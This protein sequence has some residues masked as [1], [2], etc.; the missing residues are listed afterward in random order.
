MTWDVI[1]IGLGAMGSATAADLAGRG[2]RV[3]GLD[4]YPPAHDRG[5]SHGRSR[6]I[7][8]AYF[9]D[10]SY[11]PMVWRSYELWADLERTS[12]RHLFR[13]TGGI[14][15]GRPDT[16]LVRGS[17]ESARIHRLA[18]EV[19]DAAAIRRRFP[20]FEPDND[21]VGV[22]E[23]RAGILAPEECVRA[24]LERA[25]KA[26]AELRH[27]QRVVGWSAA[28]DHV[29]V[30]TASGRFEAE[31]LVITAGPW[32]PTL[33]A[34][35]NVPMTIE[36]QVVAWF[37][38]AAL[39]EAFAPDRCPIHI[40]H[41]GRRMFYGFPALDDGGVKI[42]EHAIGDPTTADEIRRE[43]AAA[44]IQEIRNDFIARYMPAAN[45]ELVLTTV[46][47]YTM[48]PDTHF[49]IDRHPRH[50]NVSLACG[51]S[52]H[53]FKFAPAVGEILA[54]LAIDGRTRH[55]ITRFSAARFAPVR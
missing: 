54:D 20:V 50:P 9:E 52:G 21:M 4:Q 31:S 15:I 6:I 26:G 42:A 18:H 7:R 34:G 48:T 22:L 47:M 35:L 11:V 13:Q 3:L 37:R 19:L 1:V 55:D 2:L 10:P 44:E 5:S 39:Q 38:P 46:C 51:F 32:A 33:L 29:T 30:E 28:P 17:L 45:G 40:W 14:M 27:D 25:H 36:R 53:G 41:V 43:I 23:P 24:L 8:E 12:S 16:D 49:V